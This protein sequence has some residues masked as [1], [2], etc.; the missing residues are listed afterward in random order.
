MKRSSFSLCVLALVLTVSAGSAEASRFFFSTTSANPALTNPTVFMLPGQSASLYA[1]WAPTTD[2]TYDNE[3]L[4]GW[5]HDIN[6]SV[7]CI[8]ATTYTVLN[9]TSGGSARWGSINPDSPGTFLVNDA[10]AVKVGGSNLGFF[11]TANQGFYTVSGQ[12]VWRLSTVTFTAT[13]AGLTSIRFGVGAAGIS[14]QNT[15]TARQINFGFGDAS[16]S[17]NSFGSMT[18]IADA[19]VWVT[20][21][22]GSLALMGLGAIGLVAFARKRRRTTC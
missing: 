22:P 21:E 9:P 17:S 15:P 2:D 16:V 11:T 14:F 8:T 20:P 4:S 5:S 12:Q 3:Q 7:P 6:S 13:T 19:T 10:N 18:T 1:F